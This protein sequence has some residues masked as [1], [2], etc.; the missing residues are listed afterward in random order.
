MTNLSKDQIVTILKTYISRYES[1][2]KA[3]NSL[4]GVSAA[5]IS[6][7]VNGK[8]ELIKDEMWRNVAAQIGA[9]DTNA[10]VTVE[11]SAFKALNSLLTDAQIHSNVFGVIGKAGSSKTTAMKAYANNPDA[12]RLQCA[13]Y[14]NRKYFLSELLS[15]MG[16]DYSGMTVA[17]MMRDVVATLKKKDKPVIILDEADKLTDQVLY[18]FITLYNELEN[19]CG[20]VICATNF[21]SKRI[22][23]GLQ[24]NK[25]GYNEIYSRIGRNFIELPEVSYTDVM[26]VCV[27]N[28]ISKDMTILTDNGKGGKVNKNAIEVIFQDCDGDLRRVQRKV[29]AIKQVQNAA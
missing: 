22:K 29:H 28:G 5:T 13:E 26:Q 27:A 8:W 3:A 12:Y 6:Q 15:V 14:W 16:R 18:F 20:I 17:E 10:W 11:T 25:K 21:L 2:N 4:K 1:Q 9:S 7:M 19:H 24:L 23:K